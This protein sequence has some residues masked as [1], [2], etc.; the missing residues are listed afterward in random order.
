MSPGQPRLIIT[1]ATPSQEKSSNLLKMGEE[2]APEEAKKANKDTYDD[3]P[4]KRPVKQKYSPPK[5]LSDGEDDDAREYVTSKSGSEIGASD[6]E[7]SA[8]ASFSVHDGMSIAD[9]F[10]WNKG[11]AAARRHAKTD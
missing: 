8:I 10:G 11:N 9:D 2:R 4:A 6:S 7:L 5:V 3:K 1:T